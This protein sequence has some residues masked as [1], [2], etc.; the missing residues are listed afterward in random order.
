MD[1]NILIIGAHSELAF[2]TIE[3]LK[4]DDFKIYATSRSTNIMDEKV[5]ELH[6]DVLNEM[7][8]IRL[9][10]K[11]NNV[12]FNKIINFTGIAVVS[13]VDEIDEIELKK[14]FDVNVLGLIRII[15][16]FSPLLSEKGILYNVSSMASYGIFP[17]LSPYCMSKASSDIALNIFSIETG[18]KVV[19]IRPGSTAT[20][21]WE[22]SIE[23]NK[24]I[25]EEKTEKYKEEKD[26]LLKN[27]QRN[28]LHA[29]NP[30]YVSKK[31]AQIIKKNN[32][33]A[34]YNIGL[35]AKTAKMASFL[36]QKLVN[37]IVR[38]V[39]KTKIKKSK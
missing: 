38:F 11:L 32:P 5:H 16:Y 15:K 31:I 28:S 1:N 36:P 25:F 8:F 23:L 39:F 30:I 37:N 3:E 20:R 9:R 14:Q 6:L 2:R 26:F 35:D 7:D 22:H 10:D 27:A 18:K 24:K 21:F 19:S 13:S 33:K 12:K 4:S 34:V 17:F 29:K